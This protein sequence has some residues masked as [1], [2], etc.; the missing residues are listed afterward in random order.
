MKKVPVYLSE[1]EIEEILKALADYCNENDDLQERLTDE[2]E[3][4]QG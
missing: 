3:T 1:S 2:L 4:F